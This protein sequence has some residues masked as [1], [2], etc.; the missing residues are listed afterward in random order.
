MTKKHIHVF[1]HFGLICTLFA[2]AWQ[3]EPQRR[4]RKEK[5]KK[6]VLSSFQY[7]KGKSGYAIVLRN[8]KCPV[9]EDRTLNKTGGDCRR[10]L[11]ERKRKEKE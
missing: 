1:E 10:I 3:N 5:K 7:R 2:N 8:I 6:K 4:R 9:R 11:H